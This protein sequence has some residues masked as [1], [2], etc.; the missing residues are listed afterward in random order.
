MPVRNLQES[1]LLPVARCEEILAMRLR[2]D[3]L[4]AC[5]ISKP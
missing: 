5:G 2:Q 1:A 3:V 4:Q